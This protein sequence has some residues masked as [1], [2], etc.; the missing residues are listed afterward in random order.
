[1]TEKEKMLA[2][3]IYDPADSAL[4][5]ERQHARQL[6]RQFNQSTETE[7]KLRI[8]ILKDLFQTSNSTIWIEPS[9]KC[10]YG[11]NIKFGDKVFINFDCIILDTAQVS[12]GNNVMLGPG[13]HIYTPEHPMEATQRSTWKEKS[14]P[15]LIADDVWIGGGA[16][17]CPGVT[18]GQGSVIGAGSVVTKD[19]P[20]GV[21]AVGNPCRVLRKIGPEDKLPLNQFS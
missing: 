16:I 18:I 14:S 9:F 20:A 15:V 7:K 1:M 2:G 13:V 21:V 6:C 19:I 5:K 17:I 12:L 11:Y 10:D 3:Y 4:S 8:K